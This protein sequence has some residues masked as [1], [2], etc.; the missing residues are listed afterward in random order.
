MS[1]K[2]HVSI[3]DDHQSIVDGYLFRLNPLPDIK[4][5]ATTPYAEDIFSMLENHPTDVLILDVRVPISPDNNNSYPILYEI[6]RIFEAHPEL[7]ILVISAYASR[8]FVRKML[9]AGI[10]GYILKDDQ[11][12]VQNLGDVIRSAVQGHVCLSQSIQEELQKSYSQEI[13]LTPR[14]IDI[15]SLLISHPNVT[16]KEVAKR[17]HI[18]PSTARNLLS[19]AYLRLG[20]RN[21]GAALIKVQE[22]GLVTHPPPS[23]L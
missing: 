16:T 4:I 19:D 7:V 12:L 2:I 8:T 11:K 9:Q 21:R 22:M 20:V 23:E 1:Q 18:A 5:V 15:F 13:D 10:N 14:Q 17:L 6:P 3:L